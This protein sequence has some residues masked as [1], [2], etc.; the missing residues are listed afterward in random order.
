MLDKTTQ[1]ATGEIL[2]TGLWSDGGALAGDIPSCGF[3]FRRG[4]GLQGSPHS[5]SDRVCATTS[6]FEL[7]YIGQ[8]IDGDT[9]KRLPDLVRR[10]D[11]MVADLHRCRGGEFWAFEDDAWLRSNSRKSAARRVV[12]FVTRMR[13]DTFVRMS[14]S[15]CRVVN[16][17]LESDVQ[18]RAKGVGAAYK[19]AAAFRG[20]VACSI[21]NRAVGLRFLNDLTASS[22]TCLRESSLSMV[23]SLNVGSTIAAIGSTGPREVEGAIRSQELLSVF[24]PGYGVG[25]SRDRCVLDLG[26]RQRLHPA[27][28][29]IEM[30]ASMLPDLSQRYCDSETLLFGET[31]ASKREAGTRVA[32]VRDPVATN[33]AAHYPSTEIAGFEMSSL[34]MM[35]GSLNLTYLTVIN[36]NASLYRTWIYPTLWSRLCNC[37]YDA[38][39]TTHKV[40]FGYAPRSVLG[41][42]MAV[43]GGGAKDG[44]VLN[45]AALYMA[46]EIIG[47]KTRSYAGDYGCWCK[48]LGLKRVPETESGII[49]DAPLVLSECKVWQTGT[50]EAIRLDGGREYLRLNRGANFDHVV[51]DVA[52]TPNTAVP[53]T[54]DSVRLGARVGC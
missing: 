6:E 18:G 20:L 41:W 9:H 7:E 46:T 30:G 54:Q 13:D 21:G 16:G 37:S 26:S 27:E 32:I 10:T 34:S 29:I 52:C 43:A 39:P 31:V 33:L 8:A 25:V 3:Y 42:N 50:G 44:P 22:T 12:E 11:A 14:G 40:L 49:A 51:Q 47:K 24:G 36:E 17:M 53:P 4:A 28:G 35:L 15:V 2:G 5:G 1:W 19:L 48:A 45:S 38:L 23:A